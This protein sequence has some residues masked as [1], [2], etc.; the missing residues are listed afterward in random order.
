MKI[1]TW[2]IPFLYIRFRHCGPYIR[3]CLIIEYP[4]HIT[5][6]VHTVQTLVAKGASETVRR[7]KAGV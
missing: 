3:D 2:F 4:V 1:R 5:R 7:V 6:A